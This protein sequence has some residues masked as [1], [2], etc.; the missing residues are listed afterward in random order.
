MPLY[1]GYWMILQQGVSNQ[2]Y[3][4]PMYE[5][6]IN[7][8]INQCTHN[9]YIITQ[10]VVNALSILSICIL[11]CLIHLNYYMQQFLDCS[12]IKEIRKWDSRESWFGQWLTNLY[13]EQD[14]GGIQLISELVN[15]TMDGILVLKVYYCRQN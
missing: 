6:L 9:Q 2:Q 8:I 15:L 12:F 4:W 3:N 5:Y 7:S 1:Y 11:Y 10:C 14:P 13:C